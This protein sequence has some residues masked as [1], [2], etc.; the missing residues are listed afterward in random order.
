[1]KN[2]TLIS[3][4]TSETKTEWS[5]HYVIENRTRTILTDSSKKRIKVKF[6]R[7]GRN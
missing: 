6:K 5:E 3:H 1:M 4:T 2:Y 7:N